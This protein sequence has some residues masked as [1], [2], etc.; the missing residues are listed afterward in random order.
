MSIEIEEGKHY[1]VLKWEQ[2]NGGVQHVNCVE[3]EDLGITDGGNAFVCTR[4]MVGYSFSDGNIEEVKDS[5]DSFHSTHAKVAIAQGLEEI[6]TA[7]SLYK[8]ATAYVKAHD[9]LAHGAFSNSIVVT[10]PTGIPK[11]SGVL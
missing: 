7:P 3:R 5:A 4:E 6:L 2:M 9:E 1:R 11:P 8:L 10:N